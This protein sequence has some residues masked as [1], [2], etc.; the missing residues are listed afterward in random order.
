MKILAIISSIFLLFNC[1]TAQN[2]SGSKTSVEN[3]AKEEF[4][5]Q[6]NFTT[7]Y[8]TD[9]TL[10]LC[11][12]IF[13]PT[14]K[15]PHQSVKFFI[16]DTS[17]NDIIYDDFIKHGKISWYGDHHLK[18]SYIPEIVQT[19]YNTKDYIYIVDVLTGK[20]NNLKEDKERK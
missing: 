1:K 17:K 13:K 9:S 12:T 20:K 18:I 15:D 14:P 10:V 3:V 2:Q 16:Y 8:N 5:T 19:N 11:K 7:N 4:G 6:I